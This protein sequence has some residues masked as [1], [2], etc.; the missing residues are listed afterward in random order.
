MIFG[1]SGTKQTVGNREV[2][3]LYKSGVRKE[4]LDARVTDLL[5]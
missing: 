3:V 1:I 2:S 4:R 5:T